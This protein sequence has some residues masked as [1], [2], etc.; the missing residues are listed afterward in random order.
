[1]ASRKARRPGRNAVTRR[2]SRARRLLSETQFNKGAVMAGS[3]HPHDE[4]G[5]KDRLKAE[6]DEARA[7]GRSKATGRIGYQEDEYPR[8]LVHRTASAP[9]AL[10]TRTVNTP[11]E[12]AAL[13]GDWVHVSELPFETAPEA[14]LGPLY[15]GMRRV[16]VDGEDQG[17]PRI[18]R[19]LGTGRSSIDDPAAPGR[20]IGSERHIPAA[21]VTTATEA[22]ATPKAEKR[23]P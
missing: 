2:A 5:E 7:S 17:P 14:S 18:D 19:P 16:V 15:G 10:T 9:G 6:N 13:D 20:L 23:T 3:N 12:E 8:T 4:K 21:R 22:V 1:M 11:E